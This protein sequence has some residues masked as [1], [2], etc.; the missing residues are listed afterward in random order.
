ML[1]LDE[2]E[3]F[4]D[5]SHSAPFSSENE[6]QGGDPA[7]WQCTPPP[8]TSPS[9]ETP[10]HPPS[11]PGSRPHS[12]PA[13]QS[14]SPPSA[15]TGT[16]KRSS[17]PVHMRRNIRKLLREHQLEA[18]TKAAQQEELERRRRLEQQRKQDFPVPLLPEYT[19]GD[20][21]KH[22]SSSSA[23]AAASQQEVK[24]SRQEVIC[25]DSSST[26]EDDSKTDEATAAAKEHKTGETH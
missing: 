25:V 8:S 10:A 9:A 11:Q 13:S 16:K 6:A 23:S 26:G 3:S 7:V 15:L 21:T 19:T 14:P 24:P 2:S 17:K 20:V 1:L 5:Q 12:R 4:A 22:V 18:V